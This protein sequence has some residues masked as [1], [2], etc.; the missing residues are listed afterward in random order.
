MRKVCPTCKTEKDYSEYTKDRQQKSGVKP[1]CK[2]CSRL[3]N[4]KYYYA[5]KE[6]TFARAKRN[7]KKASYKLAKQAVYAVFKAVRTGKLKKDRCIDCGDKKVYAHHLYGYSI[8]NQL[9]IEWLCMTHHM[10]RHHG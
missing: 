7:S 8:K 9:N 10:K 1:Y 3:R 5:H 6:Q 4:R 2:V